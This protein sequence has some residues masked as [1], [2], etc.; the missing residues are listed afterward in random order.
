MMLTDAKIRAAKPRPNSYKLTDANRLFLL[1]TL[2]GGKLW[3]WGYYF[4]GKQQGHGVRR[5]AGRLAR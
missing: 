3:R 1:V 5:L 4:D 2:S